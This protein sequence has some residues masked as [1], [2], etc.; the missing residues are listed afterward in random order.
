MNDIVT[1]TGVVATEPRHIV[2]GSGLP[3]TSFRLASSQ[4]RYDTTKQV[5]VDAA[6]NWYT[7]STFRQLAVNA[8]ASIRKGERVVLTGRLRL[9]DWGDDERKGTAVE[10][11][12][13]AIGH[14]LLWGTTAF[15]RAVSAKQLAPASERDEFDSAPDADADPDAADEVDREPALAEAVPATPF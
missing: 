15:T 9:R 14:D 8:A 1:L 5:W 13:D 6:T 2:T 10:V 11:D 3:I 12:A 7:I 4:R